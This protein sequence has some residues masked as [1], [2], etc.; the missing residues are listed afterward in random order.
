MDQAAG[1]RGSV[2]VQ[3]LTVKSFGDIPNTLHFPRGAVLALSEHLHGSPGHGSGD[4]GAP[5]QVVRRKEEAAAAL[6]AREQQGQCCPV[7]DS[8]AGAAH[9]QP[10]LHPML[11]KHREA[12][13]AQELC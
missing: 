7:K 2:V 8:E 11:P 1:H 6:P 4:V 3:K 9:P 12:W 13:A 5:G 10:E